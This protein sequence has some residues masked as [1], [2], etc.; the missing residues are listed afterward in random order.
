VYTVMESIVE[1]LDVGHV[2]VSK[3]FLSPSA[4][5]A[6]V[7]GTLICILYVSSQTPVLK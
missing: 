5:I 2:L 6:L 3:G 4:V 1:H 7:V